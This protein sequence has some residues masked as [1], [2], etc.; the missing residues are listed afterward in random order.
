MRNS[1][2]PRYI[3]ILQM[4]SPAT[5]GK[6]INNHNLTLVAKDD[7]VLGVINAK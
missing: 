6:E 3:Q 7:K 4:V 2:C 5:P 1:F